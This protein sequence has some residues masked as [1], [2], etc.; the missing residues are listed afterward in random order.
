MFGGAPLVL[1]SDVRDPVSIQ[2]ALAQIVLRGQ[3][4]EMAILSSGRGAWD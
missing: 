2:A 4:I 3:R 1:V